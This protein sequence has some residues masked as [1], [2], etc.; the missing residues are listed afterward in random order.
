MPEEEV[1]VGARSPD[2]AVPVITCCDLQY[3]SSHALRLTAVEK[4]SEH[5]TDLNAQCF[6]V[7][8]VGTWPKRVYIYIYRSSWSNSRQPPVSGSHT[9]FFR[10][11][12]TQIHSCSGPFSF[13]RLQADN[14]CIPLTN[15]V[16]PFKT[17]PGLIR[18]REAMTQGSHA[19][20]HQNT[21]STLSNVQFFWF[22]KWIRC[23][24]LFESFTEYAPW[25]LIKIK[26]IHV[27]N[28]RTNLGIWS[29]SQM[30]LTFSVR[31]RF[32]GVPPFGSSGRGRVNVMW[33][34]W[35]MRPSWGRGLRMFWTFA[36]A[37]VIEC[38]MKCC[39]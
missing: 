23:T 33:A 8:D 35:P 36:E 28:V 17:A 16:P 13:L 19:K 32:W 15:L 27:W 39:R 7:C 5:L 30:C 6:V 11:F 2:L 14:M 29:L 9:S 22:P 26:L 10:H 4:I 18:P 34:M 1:K 38:N 25:C 21:S 24:Q 12:F 20:L 37:A 31:T 3:L